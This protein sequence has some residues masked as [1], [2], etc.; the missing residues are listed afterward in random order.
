MEC[1][2]H[3]Y[4]KLYKAKNLQLLRLDRKARIR[5]FC[6]IPTAYKRSVAGCLLNAYP[7]LQCQYNDE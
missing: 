4:T 7:V 2:A 3:M 1:L 5:T 6:G